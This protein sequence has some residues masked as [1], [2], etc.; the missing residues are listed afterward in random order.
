MQLFYIYNFQGWT[1][2]ITLT[3]NLCKNTTI[4]IY[5]VTDDLMHTYD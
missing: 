3:R 4:A 1:S 5:V 2:E